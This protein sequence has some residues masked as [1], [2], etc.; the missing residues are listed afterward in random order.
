MSLR[1]PTDIIQKKGRSMPARFLSLKLKIFQKS[2]F[3][4]ELIVL[5]CPSKYISTTEQKS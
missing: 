1:T 4:N 2:R 5:F 3:Q